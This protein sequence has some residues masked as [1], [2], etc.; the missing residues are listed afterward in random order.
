MIKSPV[1]SQLNNVVHGFGS[2]AD[3][4][5]DIFPAYWAHRP[6]QHERHG[7]RIAVIDHPRQDC[8]EA[9]GMFTDRPGLLLG[10]ATADCVPVLLARMDGRQVAA[11]HV[12]W[13]GALAGIVQRFADLLRERGDEPG[14]WH[15]AL[16]PAAAACCYEVSEEIVEQFS[17]RHAL[18]LIR[19]APRP[20]RLNLSGIVHA[21]LS[22]AGLQSISACSECT[23]CYRHRLEGI[24]TGFAF[25]SY[26]RDRQTRTPIVD[27]QWSVIAIASG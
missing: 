24:D 3:K 20:R 19:V 2:R 4:M 27:V 7:T 16:G 12:G 22:R 23:M 1:L 18:P 26:R 11:L 15:A 21:Q 6:I 8:G 5:A 17:E 14:N 10:I 25:H 9:D 13:R